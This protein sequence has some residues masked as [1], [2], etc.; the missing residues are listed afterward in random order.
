M[1]TPLSLAAGRGA[2][3]DPGVLPS[4]ATLLRDAAPPHRC[5]GMRSGTGCGESSAAAGAVCSGRP[6]ALRFGGKRHRAVGALPGELRLRASEV[7]VGGGLLVD[8]ARKIE[9]L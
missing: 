8:R 3:G 6:D 1:R 2:P 5:G 4:V 9:H 7:A